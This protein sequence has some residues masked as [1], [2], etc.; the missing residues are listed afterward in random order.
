MLGLP[1]CGGHLAARLS[2]VVKRI[3]N[4]LTDDG[5]QAPPSRM[6]QC[7]SRL[8]SLDQDKSPKSQDRYHM[9]V[10]ILD[11]KKTTSIR[12][13]ELFHAPNESIRSDLYSTKIVK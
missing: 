10:L 12:A 13:E 6:H 7:L 11:L 3:R 2:H 1:A 4:Q 5:P 8:P 9:P